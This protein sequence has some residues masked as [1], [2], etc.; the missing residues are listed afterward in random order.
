MANVFLAH[1]RDHWVTKL[2]DFQLQMTSYML[3]HLGVL[4]QIIPSS[5]DLRL[6][7]NNVLRSENAN[8]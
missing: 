8:E 4:T 1:D 7:C 6:L 2:R 3:G 5:S